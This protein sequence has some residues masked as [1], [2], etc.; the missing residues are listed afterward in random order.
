MSVRRRASRAGEILYSGPP[1]GLRESTARRPRRYLFDAAR[2]R[3][4]ARRERRGAG[5]DSRGVTRNNLRDLDVD[6]PLGVFTTVTGVSGSGK[7]SLVSQALV[8][9]V[10][11]HSD[12]TRS[13]TRTTDEDSRTR[14]RRPDRRRDQRRHGPNQSPRARRSE[15]DRPHAALE[16]CDLHRA[17]SITCARSLR[18][19]RRP[20]PAAT[21]PAGFRSTWRRAL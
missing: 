12:A 5:C 19:P 9:L 6:F 16:P 14:R 15:A 7:S 17:C 1:A 3:R 8:E 10:A 4:R 11:E 18:R 13:T 20:K 21:T 2:R